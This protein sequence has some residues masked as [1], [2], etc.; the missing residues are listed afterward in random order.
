[1]KRG[2]HAIIYTFLTLALAV[3]VY[4]AI[5]TNTAAKATGQAL[6]DA[7]TQRVLEAQEHLQAI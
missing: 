5:D 2:L 3:A 1:M 7:Y 4:I 6:E